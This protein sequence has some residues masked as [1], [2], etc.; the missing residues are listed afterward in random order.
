MSLTN[1]L[2]NL[3]NIASVV[4]AGVVSNG[5]NITRISVGNATINTAVN[6]TTISTG[7]ATVYSTINATAIN[8]NSIVANGGI[9]TNGQVLT[10]NG[11][12]MAWT[13]S[14]PFT[15]G[16]AIAMAIVFGG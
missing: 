13:T 1:D 7:N 4:V 2:T 14:T 6:A 16:K 5:T 11:A 12:G 3:A 15:T 8:V 10:S 9:G